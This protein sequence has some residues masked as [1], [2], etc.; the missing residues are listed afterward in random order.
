[1]TNNQ[2]IIDELKA[3]IAGDI[4]TEGADGY[5]DA[6]AVWNAMI[7]RKP[8]I[9]VRCTGVADVINSVKL[10][11]E[12]AL[13][14]SLKA[15]GHNVAGHAVGENALMLDLSGMRSVKV[16]PATQRAMVEG[17]C[18]WCDVD[19]ETQVF[20]LATPG[21][22]ISDTG[23]AGLTLSGGIGW[24]RSRY[25]LCIDNILS[26]D[27][28]TAAGDLVHA[29]ADEN[30]DLFWAIR[31]GGGNFGVVV[32][33]EFSLH[34]FGPTAMFAAPIYPLSAGAEPIRFWRDFLADK[35][36]M[37]G[38]LVEFS[39]IPES[40]DYPEEF[41]GERCYTIAAVYAGNADEGES[42]LQPLRDLGPM[43]TDFSGQMPYCDIQKL[44][45]ELFPKGEF[46][47]YW[48]NHF[49]SELTDECIDE[50]LENAASSPSDNSISSLW[51]LG[52]GVTSV[53]SSETAFG[54]RSSAWMYSLDSVWKDKSN[55]EKVRNWTKTA[56][57]KSRKYAN[58]GRLYLNF[59]GQD[60]DSAELTR[61]A[62]GANYA[63]LAKIKAE[64]DPTN[65]FR[66]NQNILPEAS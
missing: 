22:L 42:V 6:R 53:A 46:R 17:G 34:S 51:N 29:S 7:D 12:H 18:T 32:N 60:D 27:I 54:E 30:T 41:W 24:L 47:C 63:K 64:Y 20:G 13:P 5:D 2:I 62:F 52:T 33:F 57:E 48:K 61:T 28:V 3:C 8:A 19:R 49:L 16:N 11:A 45:D 40:E 58:E 36:D 50:A 14:V 44:F 37:V 10:A 15:G 26:V 56:W 55:D 43:V 39:T 9:I 35:H 65:M 31:G 59:A 23:V 1:M 21:G 4:Y 38:S 66:F 25:G